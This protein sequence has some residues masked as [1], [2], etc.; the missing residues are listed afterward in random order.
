MGVSRLE[1]LVAWQLAQAFKLACD[2][3][4]VLAKRCRVASLRLRQKL[5]DMGT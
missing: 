5:E 2:E 4:F 1:D 3:A